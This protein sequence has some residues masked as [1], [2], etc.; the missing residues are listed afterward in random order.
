IEVLATSDNLSR[1]EKQSS[2]VVNDPKTVLYVGSKDEL[3]ARGYD[4]YA[5]NITDPQQSMS[6]NPLALIV[7]YWKR[8]DIVTATQ[9]TNTFTNT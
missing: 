6:D 8:G 9:F 4:V 5:F 7:K 2:M 3:E 1:A